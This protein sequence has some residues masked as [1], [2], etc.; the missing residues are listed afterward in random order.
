[1]PAGEPVKLPP[2]LHRSGRTEARVTPVLPPMK[3]RKRR[4]SS[5]SLARGNSRFPGS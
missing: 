5:L 1:M 4:R 2:L 3:G